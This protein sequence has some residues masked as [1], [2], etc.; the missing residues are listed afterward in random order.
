MDLANSEPFKDSC[1]VPCGLLEASIFH[2][3]WIDFYCNLENKKNGKTTENSVFPEWIRAMEAIPMMSSDSVDS[4]GHL[5]E[6]W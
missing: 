6:A 1:V 5:E 4:Y 3:P 2:V